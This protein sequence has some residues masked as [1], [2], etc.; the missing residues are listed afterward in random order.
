MQKIHKQ[1]LQIGLDLFAL[2]LLNK[3][4]PADA[5]RIWIWHVFICQYEFLVHLHLAIKKYFWNDHYFSVSWFNI[6]SEIPHKQI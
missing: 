2:Y 3:L 5:G 4:G 6:I 1:P